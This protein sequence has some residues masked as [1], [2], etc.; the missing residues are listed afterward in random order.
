MAAAARYAQE[1]GFT[2][3]LI[4]DWDHH[5]GDGTQHIFAG[6]RSVHHIS[7][8]SALDLYMSMV[9]V[10]EDGTTSAAERDGHQNIPVLAQMY[11]DDF[12]LELGLEGRYIRG[13]QILP[14]FESAL[15]QVPWRPDVVF[16]FAGFDGHIE[17]CGEGIQD[18]TEDDF[19]QLTR[20]VLRR[21]RQWHV[22]ILSAQ[23]GGY[24]RHTAVASALRH[25]RTLAS[26]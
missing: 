16:V 26:G 14:A 21:A 20:T 10:T 19:E 7:I 25:V 1:I 6:D 17:D 11:P 2:H 4:I 8:H 12:W 15:D 13:G 5:H 9:R 18:W 23:G 22:P 3:P 24:N